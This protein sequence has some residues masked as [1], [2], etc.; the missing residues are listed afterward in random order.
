MTCIF[1]WFSWNLDWDN[2]MP[3]YSMHRRE[4]FKTLYIFLCWIIYMQYRAFPLYLIYK[5]LNNSH[6]R[7]V[8]CD[9]KSDR[10][11]IYLKYMIYQ[12]IKNTPVQN[13][14]QV[15]STKILLF[16][17]LWVSSSCQR[18]Q[19]TIAQACEMDLF[20]CRLDLVSLLNFIQSHNIVSK[21]IF[22]GQAGL[23]SQFAKEF[24]WIHRVV[25]RNQYA[26]NVIPLFPE[27][28]TSCLF[29]GGFTGLVVIF[30]TI[31]ITIII[32]TCLLSKKCFPFCPCAK[33]YFQVY[34]RLAIL[35]SGPFGA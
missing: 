29:T 19:N 13:Y 17:R 32:I 7:D 24:R 28:N 12:N 20:A 33:V 10:K 3:M 5:N 34:N 25:Y 11:C 18:Q 6:V 8:C 9:T 2:I 14:L 30:I 35:W 21:S 4:N 15:I 27:E 1:F 26:Y 22:M 16:K 31:L 23:L